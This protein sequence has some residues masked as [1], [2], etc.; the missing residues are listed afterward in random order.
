MKVRIALVSALLF[1]GLAGVGWVA[2]AADPP[3]YGCLGDR[4][5]HGH[6]ESSGCE[7]E[8]NP[9]FAHVPASVVCDD[10]RSGA[11]T[12]DGCHAC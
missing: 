5:H 4:D 6:Q 1:G 7:G 9:H 2:I 12:C 11:R 10:G 8:F 3:P